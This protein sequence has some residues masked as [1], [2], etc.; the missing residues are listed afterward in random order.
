MQF[1]EG[2]SVWVPDE[3]HA[4]LAARV[5]SGSDS[6]IDVQ[7]EE[8]VKVFASKDKAFNEI[9][10]C[11]GQIDS[12]VDN[13]V[14]LDELSEGAILHHTRKRFLSKTIYT[15]VGAILVAVNPFEMLNIYTSNDIKRAGSVA[16]GGTPEPHVFSVGAAAF[17]QLQENRRNQS[18]LISGESGAGKTETTKKVLN[19]LSTVARS[20]KSGDSNEPSIEDKILQSNP[21]LEAMGNAKTLRNNNSSRFGKWMRVNFDDTFHIKGCEI[22]NYLLEKSRVVHQIQNERNYHVFYQLIKGADKQ[23][24]SA[25]CLLEAE[26][27]RYLNQSGCTSI[28]GV[29]DAVE[30]LD[31]LDAL[32]TL[33]FSP[34]VCEQMFRIFSAI[35]HIGNIGFSSKDGGDTC[36][37]L[38][39]SERNVM[40]VTNLLCLPLPQFVASLTSKTIM[41]GKESVVKPL[42]PKEAEFNRD[43][44]AMKL[45][46]NLFDWV[47]VTL[48]SNLRNE[49]PMPYFIG[50]LDIFGFEVFQVNSFEQLCINYAN[51]KLQFHFNDVIF[52]GEIMMY[53]SEGVPAETIK[54]SI[55][56]DDNSECVALIEGKPYGLLSLLEEECSLGNATDTSYANKIGKQFGNERSSTHNKFYTKHRTQP[57]LFS[58]KHFA[59]PVEYTVKDWLEKNKDTLS[60]TSQQTMCKSTLQLVQTLFEEKEPP[61]VEGTSPSR[62]KGKSNK[63]TLGMQ[64]RN[65]LIGLMSQL[66]ITEPHFIR[67]VKPNHEKVPSRFHGELVLRQ[68]RYAGLFEAIRIRK[69]GFAFRSPH[70][71]FADVFQIIHE[72]LPLA[73]KKA[74]VNNQQACQMILEEVT[75]LGKMDPKDWFVGKTKVFIK[76]GEQ[77][78]V[79]ERIKGERM[80]DYVII[81]QAVIRSF[82]VRCRHYTDLVKLKYVRKQTEATRIQWRNAATKIQKVFRRYAVDIKVEALGD[83][84]KLRRAVATRNICL[85]EAMYVKIDS[86]E[87]RVAAQHA[88]QVQVRK[89]KID[90]EPPAAAAPVRKLSRMSIKETMQRRTSTSDFFP[91]PAEADEGATGE[92]SAESKQTR[93]DMGVDDEM[94]AMGADP[95]NA[96]MASSEDISRTHSLEGSASSAVSVGVSDTSAASYASFETKGSDD[97]GPARGFMRASYRRRSAFKR[98]KK[99]GKASIFSYYDN[100][101][102]EFMDLFHREALNVP[103]VIKLLIIQN[104]FVDILEEVYARDN[105]PAIN[106]VLAKIHGMGMDEIPIVQQAR[107][108]IERI[109][110]KRKVMTKMALFLQNEEQAADSNIGALLNEARD[111]NVSDEYV[112]KVQRVYDS[113]GPR[114]KLRN[115]LRKAVEL[116]DGRTLRTCLR[117]VDRLRKYSA[118]FAEVEIKAARCMLRMLEFDRALDHTKAQCEPSLLDAVAELEEMQSRRHSLDLESPADNTLHKSK[119]TNAH[120]C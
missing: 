92:A 20:K 4:W 18:V 61:P 37:I 44:L 112:T 78:L 52:G 117:D 113:A 9:A 48:N 40:A 39:E 21:L 101:N 63:M 64:F 97:N 73:R 91:A 57:Q 53:E 43:S 66:Q 74:L 28:A 85:L 6:R 49:H 104:R 30:F 70:R 31:V 23:L 32:E 72:D 118:E 76:T 98:E 38:P 82:L 13:L 51:E 102:S 56:F 108:K 71:H 93:E 96:S 54:E 29:D 88:Q 19:Y 99:A 90:K 47:V 16:A 106:K 77:K 2:D 33:K 86:N 89:K 46:G 62:T 110:R 75:R 27:F 22:V 60:A 109:H 11:G 45:Y 34:Q 68:L 65:Q 105:V 59:G 69:S 36:Q 100:K 17:L 79:L 103:K 7:T 3:F 14:E 83:L 67:C 15:Y 81:G 5:I 119:N 115:K 87:R 95:M 84:V 55:K 116:V 111:L 10:F 50:I 114:L 107:R 41:V 24:K 58:V 12:H 94:E 80:I 26:D 120:G 42:S 25:L 8:G 35:L 1:S